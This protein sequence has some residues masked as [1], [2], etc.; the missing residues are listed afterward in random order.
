MLSG[1]FLGRSFLTKKKPDIGSLTLVKGRDSPLAVLD[2]RRRLRGHLATAPPLTY[3]LAIVMSACP[4]R[5]GSA[6]CGI[7]SGG[8][9]RSESEWL[10]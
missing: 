10:R 3:L 2:T 5:I 8:W 7:F 1:A 4:A 9:L 6:N